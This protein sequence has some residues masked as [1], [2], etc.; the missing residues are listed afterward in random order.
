MD[1]TPGSALV[2]RLRRGAVGGRLVLQP[3]LQPVSPPA[4]PQDM[5]LWNA[6]VQY[7]CR[8]AARQS[9]GQQI[10]G[11]GRNPGRHFRPSQ[12][13]SNCTAFDPT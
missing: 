10:R 1:V 13:A 7:V 2:S 6:E 5:L 8:N 11:L 4:H 12:A 9:H 3:A